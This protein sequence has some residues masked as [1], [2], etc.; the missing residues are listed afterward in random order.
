MT[1]WPATLKIRGLMEQ[2]TASDRHRND[3]LRLLHYVDNYTDIFYYKGHFLDIG[4][5]QQQEMCLFSNTFANY[6]GYEANPYYCNE[7]IDAGYNVE[8]YIISDKVGQDILYMSSIPGYDSL[9]RSNAQDVIGEVTVPCQTIDNLYKDKQRVDI[10]NIDVEG[11]D[12]N[13]ILGARQT[14]EKHKPLIVIEF[15]PDYLKPWLIS[16]GYILTQ[17]QDWFC[18]QGE[19]K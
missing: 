16:Q 10:L 2:V 17:D 4:V 3:Y 12:G 18:I 8:N 13:V 19:K 14:I 1:N 7:L 6:I 9:I 11:H 15:L 5:H